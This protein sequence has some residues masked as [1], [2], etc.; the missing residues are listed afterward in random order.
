MLQYRMENKVFYLFIFFFYEFG[1][2]KQLF[3]S[4]FEN[5]KLANKKVEI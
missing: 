4:R 3:F 1:K 5:L 2:N